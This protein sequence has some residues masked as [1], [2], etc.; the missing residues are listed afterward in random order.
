MYMCMYLNK[1]MF[2]INI[3][4]Y[5]YILNIKVIIIIINELLSIDYTVYTI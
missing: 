4:I 5:I 3:Y 1:S 2:C